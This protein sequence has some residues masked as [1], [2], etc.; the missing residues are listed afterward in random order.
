MRKNYSRLAKVEEKKSMRQ[1]VLFAVLSLTV[2]ISFVFLGVPVLAKLASFAGD[3]KNGK[4]ISLKDDNIVPTAPFFE[5]LPEYTNAN[6]LEIVGTTEAGS[7]VSISVNGKIVETISDDNGRFSAELGLQTGENN[8]KASAKDLAGNVSSESKTIKVTVDK[9]SPD[10]TITKPSNN[11]NFYGSKQKDVT[12][13]GTTE[14]GASVT[15]NDKLATSDENGN[16]KIIITLSNDLNEL[17]IKSIDKA[18]NS[19]EKTLSLTYSD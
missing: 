5:S 12:I 9:D 13:E 19:F 15:V 6:T 14:Q 2:I 11:T 16:F 10:L 7:T 1:A 17:L 18:G 3:I 4:N 8:I